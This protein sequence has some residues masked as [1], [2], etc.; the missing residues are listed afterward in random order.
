MDM[1]NQVWSMTHPWL[2]TKTTGRVH[3]LVD[4]I[5]PN[6]F[7]IDQELLSK[8]RCGSEEVESPDRVPF[9][10]LLFVKGKVGLIIPGPDQIRYSST[11]LPVVACGGL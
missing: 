7:S 5:V 10:S 6:P 11:H 3:L 1:D 4:R 2:R 9:D 8:V